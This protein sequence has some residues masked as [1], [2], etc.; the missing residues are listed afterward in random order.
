MKYYMFDAHSRNEANMPTPDGCTVLTIPNDIT[1]V[2]LFIRHLR[3]FKIKK[4]IPFEV[5]NITTI[6]D[7]AEDL[8]T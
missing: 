7:Q 4:D 2:S 1:Y 3:L 5:A 8:D 6:V